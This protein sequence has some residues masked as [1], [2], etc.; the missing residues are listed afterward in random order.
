MIIFKED[1]SFITRSDKPNENWTNNPD[2]Y[3]V[4]DNSELA[5][6]I[7]QAYPHYNFITDGNDNLID[8]EVLEMP[9]L[10]QVPTL[11]ERLSAT[12]EAITFLMGV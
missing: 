5:N 11:E 8:I 2:V 9:T 7:I 12:E 1:K 3:V 10:V 6:K 4:E